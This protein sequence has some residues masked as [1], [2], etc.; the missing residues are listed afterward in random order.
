MEFERRRDD[1]ESDIAGRVSCSL[2]LEDAATERVM[3]M[4]KWAELL[5]WCG[6]CKSFKL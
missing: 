3:K 6:T 4:I 2:P 1:E 5:E